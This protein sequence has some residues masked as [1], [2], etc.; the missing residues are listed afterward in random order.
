MLLEA[1]TEGACRSGLEN[2]TP[3]F[4]DGFLGPSLAERETIYLV[5]HPI[6]ESSIMS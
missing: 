3:W 4:A 2:A 5:C 6:Y 1:S